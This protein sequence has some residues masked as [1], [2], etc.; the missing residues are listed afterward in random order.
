[1]LRMPGIS[2]NPVKPLSLGYIF[3]ETDLINPGM[4]EGQAAAPEAVPGMELLGIPRV[5]I[6][7]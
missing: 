5:S 7:N 4:R 1:M 2:F 6:L 3:L